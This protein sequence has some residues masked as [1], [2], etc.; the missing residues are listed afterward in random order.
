[1][2]VTVAWLDVGSDK[3]VR[4]RAVTCPATRLYGRPLAVYEA[5]Q[6]DAARSTGAEFDGETAD[7]AVGAIE[8]KLRQF[9]DK[10]APPAD[11]AGY[12]PASAVSVAPLR[13]FIVQVRPESTYCRP[14]ESN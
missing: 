3:A 7:E 4:Q 8:T 6:A 13:R 10:A 9:Y 5:E 14:R 1:M 11:P 12:R 2:D